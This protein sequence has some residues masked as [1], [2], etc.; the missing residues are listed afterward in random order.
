MARISA[1][2]GATALVVALLAPAL[3]K[4]PGPHYSAWL[5][6][7]AIS[8]LP[9]SSRRAPNGARRNA[10]TRLGHLYATGRGVPQNMTLAAYWYGRAAEQGQPMAQFLLGLQYD[11]GQGVDA[12]GGRVL[13]LAQSGGGERRP[14]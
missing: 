8:P 11:K 12:G 14:G 1:L 4:S 6:A 9:R 10:Q 2:A 13:S 3:A 5:R 7:A